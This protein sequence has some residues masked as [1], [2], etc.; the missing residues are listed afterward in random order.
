MASRGFAVDGIWRNKLTPARMRFLWMTQCVMV[1][2]ALV[3]TFA[4]FVRDT[5]HNLVLDGLVY[6]PVPI[7]A[8]ILCAAR[9]AFVADAERRGWYS[10]GCAL[11]LWAS[12]DAFSVVF[13][14]EQVS[15]GQ[16]GYVLFYPLAYIGAASIMRARIR[17]TPRSLWLD[18]VACALTSA[19]VLVATIYEPLERITNGDAVALVIRLSY[20]V[21]E[22][23][24]IAVV[25]ACFSLSGWRPDRS[26]IVLSIGIG[27][28]GVADLSYLVLSLDGAV[29]Q[30]LPI[31]SLWTLGF[32][33]MG[34]APWQR[35]RRVNASVYEHRAIVIMPMIFACVS[36][37]VLT[38]DHFQRVP[39]IAVGLAV[40]ALLLVLFRLLVI[41][42]EVRGLAETRR[43]AR[44][45]ELTELG[46]RRMFYERTA[47]LLKQRKAQNSLALLL[48]DLDRFKAVNDTLG[49]QAGDE[50]LR[51]V[52]KRLRE[53]VRSVDDLARLGGDEFAV[54]LDNTDEPR[55]REIA[56][57]I[58]AALDLPFDFE[59]STITIGGSVGIAMFPAEG[60][61]TDELMRRADIS[62]Y[63]TKAV[64]KTECELPAPT[65]VATPRPGAG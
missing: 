28:I 51:N 59:G 30:G 27:L 6:L 45:D 31:D 32:A 33:F 29:E 25:V 15:L 38:W 63:Q 7:G 2:G 26:W 19:A 50:V 54:V 11:A 10:F 12:A 49:H 20:P 58:R 41:Y 8:A 42:D 34:M 24:F 61:D 5:G 47:A 18:G 53:I 65:T 62:M 13:Q 64:R 48:I 57:R 36:V 14:P 44:T 60:R 9:A 40:A 21:F 35:S 16:I 17:R 56:D 3:Y 23:L 55:A 4:N 46:N 39:V 43:E 1:L 22:V 52:G 37:A